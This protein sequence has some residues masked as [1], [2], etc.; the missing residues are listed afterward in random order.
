M[1]KINYYL[2]RPI[3]LG[4]ISLGKQFFGRPAIKK[5][6]EI[7]MSGEYKLL[8]RSAILVPN[9][10][11]GADGIILKTIIDKPIHFLVQKEGIYDSKLKAFLWTIGEIPVGMDNRSTYKQAV[12][13][14]E[15]YLGGFRDYIGIFSEGPTKA[16]ASGCGVI[17]LE[18]RIHKTGAAHLSIN[19]KVPIIPIGIYSDEEAE[20]NLW[21]FEKGTNIA[22]DYVKNRL[23]T[24][25]KLPYR[26]NIGHAIY[27]ENYETIPKKERV[28]EITKIVKE[29]IIDLVKEMKEKDNSKAD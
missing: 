6:L 4:S 29:K 18:E 8:E 16:L 23:M 21:S 13:R 28:N 5:Y 2:K 14:A 10:C 25:G 1:A 19:N 3:E 11:I 17:P 15:D 12:K 20:K 24:Q 26:V 9:H 27:P 22:W 7:S